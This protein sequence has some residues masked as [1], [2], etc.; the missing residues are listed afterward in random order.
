VP[1]GRLVAT[2]FEFTHD[3]KQKANGGF[4]L[5]IDVAKEACAGQDGA[6]PND[7]PR[8]AVP[9]DAVVAAARRRRPETERVA[10]SP[11][12]AVVK[13]EALPSDRP[14]TIEAPERR[15]GGSGASPPLAG[16]TSTTAGQ[17][18][19]EAV[20]A[21]AAGDA[22]VVPP[23]PPKKKRKPILP[24]S[25]DD[26]N[27][28]PPRRQGNEAPAKQPAKKA[29]AK[30]PANEAPAKRPADDFAKKRPA[31]EAPAKRPAAVTPAKRPADDLAKKRQAAAE[32]PAPGPSRKR[33][34]APFDRPRP[35]APRPPPAPGAATVME[36]AWILT[37]IGTHKR[38]VVYDLS[39]TEVNV[40]GRTSKIAPS[41][42][43]KVALGIPHEA[44]AIS[45]AHL[46]L[47]VDARGVFARASAP[48][49]VIR[50]ASRFILGPDAPR[51]PCKTLLAGDV[52]TLDVFMLQGGRVVLRDSL[53]ALYKYELMTVRRKRPA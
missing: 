24:D 32:P 10:A 35:E 12:E 48:M 46:E 3:A 16:V 36:T 5:K 15:G 41:A 40:V 43:T 18:R 38:H 34:D 25:D 17:S 23:P 42:G 8:P 44:D 47:R 29:S 4:T 33:R 39:S 1:A 14:S 28:E 31:A 27:E 2:I 50:G 6:L 20:S 45:R 51:R 52:F 13:K 30:R 53:F 21:A 26:E 7:A 19:E 9:D 37:S 49:L 11:R 22:Y